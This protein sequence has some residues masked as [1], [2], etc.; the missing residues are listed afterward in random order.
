MINNPFKKIM[1]NNKIK[2]EL[3]PGFIAIIKE[4]SFTFN[5][6]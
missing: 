2:D 4:I 5:T 3:K 1:I 6:Y